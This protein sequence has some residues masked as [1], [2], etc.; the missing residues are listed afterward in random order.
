MKIL[1]G[2]LVTLLVGLLLTSPAFGGWKEKIVFNQFKAVEYI[3]KLQNGA[4]PDKIERPYLRYDERAKANA[5][6]KEI[7]SAMEKAEE[8]ARQG[9]Y[10]LIEIPEFKVDLVSDAYRKQL[11]KEYNERSPD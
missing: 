9:R 1:G 10:D 8:L 5:A 2:L 3:E 6:N 7:R 4:D 11:N